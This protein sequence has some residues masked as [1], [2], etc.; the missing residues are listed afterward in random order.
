MGNVTGIKFPDQSCCTG[1]SN[2]CNVYLKT[3]EDYDAL[4]GTN[5]SKGP[6][7]IQTPRN[8]NKFSNIKIQTN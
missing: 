4:Y 3:V 8:P 2:D 5:N 6:S 7:G 1:N